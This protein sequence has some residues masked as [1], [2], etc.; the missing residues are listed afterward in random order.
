MISSFNIVILLLIFLELFFTLLVIAMIAK[1]K[2]KETNLKNEN[3]HE[4]LEA[5]CSKYMLTTREA[6]ILK[7]LSEGLPY[8]IIADQLNIS[9]RTVTSHVANMFSKVKVTNKMELVSKML[10]CNMQTD[11]II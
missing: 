6:Q 2:S 7:L 9:L 5:N 11:K 1:M 8:K 3:M 10:E 4:A